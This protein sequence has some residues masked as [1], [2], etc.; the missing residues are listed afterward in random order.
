MRPAPQKRW[1][2][3]SLGAATVF[4]CLAG[5][6]GCFIELPERYD[7]GGVPVFDDDVLAGRS[8]WLDAA[9]PGTAP[10]ADPSGVGPPPVRPDDPDAAAQPGNPPTAGPPPP[11]TEQPPDCV[12]RQCMTCDAD[13]Q[14][15]PR[16]SDPRCPP[17]SCAAFQIIDTTPDP[18]TGGPTCR[19]YET[20]MPRTCTDD[21]QCVQRPSAELCSGRGPLL[22]EVV[23]PTPCYRIEGCVPQGVPT[24]VQTP[25]AACNGGQGVCDGAGQCI[26][27][28]QP[29]DVCA[30]AQLP[31]DVLATPE[32]YCAAQ[33][34]A[35]DVCRF[36]ILLGTVDAD[37]APLDPEPTL[38][39]AYFCQVHGWRCVDVFENR[40]QDECSLCELSDG[41]GEE[42]CRL[43]D[44]CNRT[45]GADFDG[46]RVEF[47]G[48]LCDCRVPG[49]ANPGGGDDRPH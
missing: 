41:L 8:P 17:V 26:P 27:L 37:Q 25:G 1:L 29:T 36:R 6:P 3:R 38:N 40:W 11:A 18:Q 35:A 10:D 21:G 4:V 34:P 20:S 22:R 7:D 47:D 12:A 13:G 19:Q 31:S 30:S 16:D 23:A 33:N 28:P 42:G 46:I 43:P 32:L 44:G 9:P 5:A 15:V 48:L 14:L 2:R 24:L 49:G 39:C 45:F